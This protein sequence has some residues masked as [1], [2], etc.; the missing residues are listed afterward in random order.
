MDFHRFFFSFL[1]IVILRPSLFLLDCKLHK[2]L[3]FGGG[4]LLFVLVILIFMPEREVHDTLYDPRISSRNSSA[5]LMYLARFRFGRD[6]KVS[7]YLL[8]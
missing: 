6:R 3:I 2:G 7:L 4:T 8:A 5:S 1:D